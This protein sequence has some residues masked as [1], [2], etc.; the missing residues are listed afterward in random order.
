MRRNLPDLARVL[1][2]LGWLLAALCAA[3]ATA[4]HQCSPDGIGVGGFDLV[5]YHQA[6]GPL[7]GLPEFEVEVERDGLRYRFANAE[8]L[9]RFR[10]APEDY[11]PRYRGWCAA[12]LSMGRL[13]C[14]DYTNFKVEDGELLLF[15]LA[16]FTNGRTLWN[17]DPLRFRER[18]DANAR[19]LLEP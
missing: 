12:T 3:P 2:G 11:L 19:K 7:P 1:L 9:A 10:A 13:T 6:G 5:S 16:G 4:Q 15:E 14:P 8:N 18:A 17:S